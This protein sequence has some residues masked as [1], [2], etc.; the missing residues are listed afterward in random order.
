MR[1]WKMARDIYGGGNDQEVEYL[2]VFAF[3]CLLS[4]DVYVKKNLIE[5]IVDEISK[6]EESG[7]S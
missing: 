3:V 7:D 6:F 4:F 5:S 1:R 2:Q